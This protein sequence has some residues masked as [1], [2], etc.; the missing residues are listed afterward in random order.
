MT[1]TEG[2][3]KKKGVG[4]VRG[5]GKDWE[6]MRRQRYEIKVRRESGGRWRGRRAGSRWIR[7]PEL[8]FGMKRFHVSTHGGVVTL[9]LR[10]DPDG[11]TQPQADVHHEKKKQKKKTA[12]AKDSPYT[13]FSF[14]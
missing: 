13:K 12:A 6:K 14:K 3:K 2:T 5:E 8:H 1:L 10:A 9:L 11:N 7:S 4:K